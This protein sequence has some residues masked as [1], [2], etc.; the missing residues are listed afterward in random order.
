MKR[1]GLLVYLFVSVMILPK[2]VYAQDSTFAF[3]PKEVSKFTSDLFKFIQEGNYADIEK[4]VDSS[5]EFVSGNN[6]S[7]LK[8]LKKDFFEGS[9][10]QLS[11]LSSWS[12]DGK[13]YYMFFKTS[14]YKKQLNNWH[15]LFI[16]VNEN[17]DVKIK[18]WHKS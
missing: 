13:Y 6:Q 17:K 18:V 12:S 7:N 11:K 2:S 5:V 15:S 16:E 14:N 10:S 4:Y 9:D 3:L 8:S 1:F